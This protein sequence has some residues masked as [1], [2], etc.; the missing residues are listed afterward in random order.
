[1][2]MS[3]LGG[4]EDALRLR[5]GLFAQLSEF[6]KE[7]SPGFI[8][9]AASGR[10]ARYFEECLASL[11]LDPAPAARLLPENGGATLAADYRRLFLGPLPPYVVPVESIYKRWT[12]APDCQLPFAVGKGHLMGD[13]AI[14]MARLYRES[15]LAVPEAFSSMPDH[16]ALELEYAA[17]LSDRDAGAAAGFLRRHLDWLDD[18]LRDIEDAGIGVFYATGARIARDV[19][20]LMR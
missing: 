19:V 6:F 1:M 16:L 20:A 7:P 8:E 14:D 10:L 2:D 9:D 12:T 17:F 13:A 4:R 5:A 15:G 11:G 3:D 18:L